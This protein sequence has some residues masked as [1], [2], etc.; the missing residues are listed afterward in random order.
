MCHPMATPD[1]KQL[2]LEFMSVLL[3]I[4]ASAVLANGQLP[5]PLI[6][7]NAGDSFSINVTDSLT[8]TTM[9]RSTSVHW[10]GLFQATTNDM[11][12]VPWINQCPLVPGEAYSYNFATNSKSLTSQYLVS[13]TQTQKK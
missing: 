7:A 5:G 10:H 3:N 12:G 13:D 4:C 8:D 1:R 11:D 9:H 6:T 2:A